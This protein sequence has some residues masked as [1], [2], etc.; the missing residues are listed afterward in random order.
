MNIGSKLKL[1]ALVPL[2]VSLVT[3]LAL[4]FSYRAIDRAWDEGQRTKQLMNSMNELNSLARYYMLY[5]ENRPKRQFLSEYDSMTEIIASLQFRDKVQQGLLQG[6][7]D[8][9]E[10][11]RKAFLRLVAVYE[12]PAPAERYALSREAEERLIG[13]ILTRA[14]DVLSD[15][16]R[17]EALIDGEIANTQR[18]VSW[19]VIFILVTTG[20]PL[21]VVLI[22]T[23]KGITASLATVRQGTEAVGAGHLDHRIGM[24]D[25]D[26]IG[27]LSCAFDR[28]TDR[29]RNTTVSRDRLRKE[30]EERKGAEEDARRQGEWLRVTLSSIGDAV[31]ATDIQ[32]RISFLNPGAVSLTGW[33]LEEAKGRSIQGI[34]RIINEKTRSPAEDIVNRVLREGNVVNLVNHTALIHRDGRE[35]PI[36]DSAAPIRDAEGKTAGVVIVF[37]D[38]TEKRRAQG[39]ILEAAEKFR[40]VA[41]FT[42]DWEHWRSPENRFL[43]VSPSC[44][45]ISGYAPEEF[46]QDP[47]LYSRIIHPDDRERVEAHLHGEQ[48]RGETRELE[49]RI[50]H[51]DGRIRWIGHVCQAV[52]DP[53][54][55]FQGRRGSERDITDRKQAEAA[56]QEAR[57]SLEREKQILQ[58]VMDGAE[59]IHL[60]YLDRDFN[61]VRVNRVYARTCGYTAE[62]LIGKNHFTLFP[63]EENEAI[64]VRVR[65]TG[66]PA[67]FHDKPFVF[68]DQPER[69]T[70]Y[71]DWSLLPVKDPFGDVQG[72]VFSLVE[73]TERRR[74]EDALKE[75]EARLR[76]QM[77]RMPIGCILYDEK[78]HF[79][80]MN[81]AAERI[82]GF[83]GGELI[84]RHAQV[85]VPADAQP[86]VEGILHRIAEGDMTA[87]SVNENLTRDGR[88]ILCDWLNTPLRDAGGRFTGVLSMVQDVTEK[89]QAEEDLRQRTLELQ[90]LNNTLERRVEDRTAE[91]AIINKDLEEEIA[92]RNRAEE[93]ARTERRRLYEVLETLPAYVVLLTPDYQ[94]PFANRFFRER[95][96][97]SNGLRCFEFLFGRK[98]ACENCETYSAMKTHAPHHWEWAGPDGRI[99]EVSDFPFTD[100]DGSTLI[101]EMGIDITERKRAEERLKA[102]SLYARSL[103]EVS[104]DPLV[105][106]SRDGK[107][108][109]VNRATELVTGVVRERLIGTDFCHYFAEPE[110]AREGYEQVFRAGL[111]R[112]FPLAIRHISGSLTEVLYNASTYR[113]ETGEVEGVFAA[114]RDITELKRA[115]KKL[116]SYMAMLELSN[117][118]MEDFVHVASHDLQEPL[119]K[120]RT[121]SDLLLGQH[122]DSLSDK[123]R[124]Y[125]KRINLSAER[126]HTL[127]MSLLRYSRITSDSNPFTVF[128]LADP[129]REAVADLGVPCEETEGRVEVGELPDIEADRVQMR[130]LFQ[131]LISNALKYQGEGKPVVRVYGSP[132]DSGLFWDIQVED[133]G[134]GFDE[135]HLDKIFKPFQRLHGRSSPYEGTGMG[136]AI[137]RKIVERH[138]G[139]ITARS[140]PGKGSTFIVSL[141]KRQ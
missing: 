132:P 92:E 67:I 88:I 74:A 81:P 86:H 25:R 93:A 60:T 39:E 117:R 110:K 49:F 54:G 45:R 11:V 75:S 55:A 4:L 53:Q 90:Q 48:F 84:G 106:I 77:E 97:E 111:V 115:E 50:L 23:M 28:M 27:E 44:E 7:R 120:L 121:F 134:I 119:R 65:E 42:Q 21:T 31:I 13:R 140:V 35:I 130:Q 79:A 3:G 61:F 125:L 16:L 40:I 96:G 63:H 41:D 18:R 56:T 29:L 137:C 135:A 94:V 124:D 37:H 101:L 122:H 82:F 102:A 36:E 105:T 14:R 46:I 52:L 10:S 33:Q 138:G 118:E 76:L 58:S 139:V 8:N 87:H 71:W 112:D 20:V 1:A 69:G 128:N 34:F 99:Y 22:R 2:L 126:M 15:A 136:L 30:V 66:V 12:R 113:N 17:L 80:Q 19:L 107:I 5:P 108:L 64:F 133:N 70:T 85:I 114:A 109:D 59:N 26:E 141:P 6:I 129:V 43:Y 83:R 95:F 73:T 32:G 72:F 51:R 38:V 104:L 89:K 131:N 98:E 100:T 47:D 9:S 123:A 103:I 62:D 91:L 68:P 24:A 127:V 116:R 78:F 57:K